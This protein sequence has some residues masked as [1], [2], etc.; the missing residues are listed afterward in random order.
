MKRIALLVLLAFVLGTGCT[1]LESEPAPAVGAAPGNVDLVVHAVGFKHTRGHAVARLFAPGDDL[2]G[3]GRAEVKADVHGSE[4]TLSFPGLVPGSY[5][6]LVFHDENDNGTLDH[7][8][9]GPIEPTGLSDGVGH[10][11]FGPP[12][13]DKAKF[14]LSPEKAQVEIAVQ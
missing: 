5:A 6:V 9:F 14:E 1:T 7:G 4:A 13:F 10:G 8:V 2:M 3:P 12:S 11:H